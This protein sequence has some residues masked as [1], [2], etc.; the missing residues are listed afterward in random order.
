MADRSYCAL[1]SVTVVV[2]VTGSP[3]RGQRGR[4]RADDG[5]VLGAQ[6]DLQGRAGRHLAPDAQLG[7]E[8]GEGAVVGQCG[9][10]VD[11]VDRVR[12]DGPATEPDRG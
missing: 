4:H 9:Q 8:V 10:R 1:A 11:V 2:E 5:R 7:V 12:L 6:P 3:P